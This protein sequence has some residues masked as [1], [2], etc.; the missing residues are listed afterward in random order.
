VPVLIFPAILAGAVGVLLGNRNLSRALPLAGRSLLFAWVGLIAISLLL[1]FPFNLAGAA[2]IAGAV[3][4][5][6]VLAGGLLSDLREREVDILPLFGG[7]LVAAVGP[8]IDRADSIGVAG[9]LCGLL[10]AL[11]VYA[12]GRLYARLRRLGLDPETGERL[13]PLGA[14]DIALLTVL[15]AL[16]AP[17]AGAFA[18]LP[19]LIGG[20]ALH[21]VGTL[22][23]LLV[24]R[25]RGRDS[26]LGDPVELAPFLVAATLLVL[27]V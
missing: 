14:G 2:T 15:G 27:Y 11:G 9:A 5:V 26:S 17:V 3:V 18:A 12:C 16:V 7:A 1:L 13:D 10:L 19:I 22:V 25:L 6:A 20:F 4:A 8:L 21:V 24:R 23:L